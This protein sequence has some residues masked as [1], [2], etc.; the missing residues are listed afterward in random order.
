MKM[1]KNIF[2]FVISS[3]MY[4]PFFATATFLLSAQKLDLVSEYCSKIIKTPGYGK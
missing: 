3:N 1:C 4:G 2:I